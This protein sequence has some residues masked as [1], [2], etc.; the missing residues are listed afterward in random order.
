MNDSYDDEPWIDRQT[1][2]YF[3]NVKKRASWT[4]CYLQFVDPKSFKPLDQISIS[5]GI[6]IT[7]LYDENHNQLPLLPHATQ[8]ICIQISYI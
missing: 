5:I 6:E 4:M 2:S 8:V 1:E 7:D 3:V